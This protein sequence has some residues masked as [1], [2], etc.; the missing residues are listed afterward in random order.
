[1]KAVDYIMFLIILVPQIMK[2]HG[3]CVSNKQ[4]Y[5]RDLP[6]YKDCCYKDGTF[7]PVSGCP[8]W[9]VAPA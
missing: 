7:L 4:L 5:V 6:C 8:G 3:M 2:V 1:M 9:K